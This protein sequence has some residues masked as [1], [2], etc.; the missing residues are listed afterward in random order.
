MHEAQL[1]VGMFDSRAAPQAL[2]FARAIAVAEH[3]GDAGHI[4][5]PL[6]SNLAASLHNTGRFDEALTYYAQSIKA[7]EAVLPKWTISKMLDGNSVEKRMEFV[8]QRM[9]LASRGEKPPLGE[10]LSAS[11]QVRTDGAEQHAPRQ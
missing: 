11:N 5:G 8:Q 3:R 10:W 4:L 7:F 9:R 1:S 2:R 6:R